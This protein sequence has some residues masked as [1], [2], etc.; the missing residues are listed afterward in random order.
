V[1]SDIRP[2]VGLTRTGRTETL[3]QAVVAEALSL[4]VEPWHVET[5]ENRP[6]A[7]RR[8]NPET[9]LL[10]LE[11]L[12][13][14]SPSTTG[15]QSTMTMVLAPERRTPEVTAIGLTAR[16]ADA[17]ELARDALLYD[18]R[19]EHLGREVEDAVR[20]FVG[21]CYSDRATDHVREF[22]V[23]HAKEPVNLVCYV[24][25]AFLKVAG[26]T[27]VLGLHLLPVDDPRLPSEHRALS[28]EPPVGCVAAVAAR[29]TNYELMADRARL[30]V[31]H[32][33]RVLRVALREHQGINDRQLRFR[34][35]D[36]YAF[37]ERASGRQAPPEVAYELGL[38]GT[39]IDLAASQPISK[40]PLEPVTDVAK[41]ADLALRWMERARFAGEPLV[42]LLFLFFGLEALLGDK[43]EGLKAHGL[44]LRQT[45]LS[46]IATGS[47]TDP[48]ET[49]FL[50]DDVRSGA[51]HGE[52]APTVS[53]DDVGSF[54]SVVRDALNQYLDYAEAQGLSRRS[55][56]LRALDEHPDAPKL[57]AWLRRY[58]G[59]EWESYFKAI[60]AK[61][62]GAGGVPSAV[63]RRSRTERA[64]SREVGP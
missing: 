23:Q 17:F 58:A 14:H 50:Y 62:G 53:W 30:V 13:Q 5:R 60:E 41:K 38:D 7:P 45:M 10:I 48:N 34:V 15:K 29:G 16:E 36:T 1:G 51:V 6:V 25:V 55:R 47:F 35:G 39:L 4:I 42:A 54:A 22:V 52:D 40:M 2:S 63:R 46:H 21:D 59:P 26:E 56:L 20:H 31:A 24:P 18:P 49:Y 37:S 33:L 12:V 44:A 27:E 8:S 43:S 32:A 61:R 57:A 11:R 9:A 28:L 19:F 64:A 3:A